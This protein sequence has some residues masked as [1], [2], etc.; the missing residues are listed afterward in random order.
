[1]FRLACFVVLA[2]SAESSLS[3]AQNLR[4]ADL[5][6]SK[7][8]KIDRQVEL[9]K[10]RSDL[11]IKASEELRLLDFK[12]LP[13][14]NVY[15][16]KFKLLGC[17]FKDFVSEMTLVE[18]KQPNGKDVAIGVDMAQKCILEVFLEK[19]DYNAISMFR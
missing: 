2:F 19:K 17:S 5:V 11:S 14:M 3:H 1:M 13:M 16:A 18:V 12:P 15:L 9:N 7:V 4:W 8:Y 6:E 10:N